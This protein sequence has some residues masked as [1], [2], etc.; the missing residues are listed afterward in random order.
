MNASLQGRILVSH[1]VTTMPPEFSR[2]LA[3]GLDSAGVFMIPQSL[4]ISAAIDEL[5]PIG[6]ASDAQ[7]WR[8]FLVWLPL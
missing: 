7:E 6:S 3:E 4:A 2:L 8:N 1:D 5:V